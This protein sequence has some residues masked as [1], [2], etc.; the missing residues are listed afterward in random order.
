[1]LCRAISDNLS[2]GSESRHRLTTYVFDFNLITCLYFG[3]LGA[4]SSVL[5]SHEMRHSFPGECFSLQKNSLEKREMSSLTSCDS[6]AEFK[7]GA[8]SCPGPP[9]GLDDSEV[10]D[11]LGLL[12]LCRIKRSFSAAKR[13]D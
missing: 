8:N 12:E 4:L 9:R 13:R 1:M 5:A 7:F 10:L 11:L 3:V 6:D 2:S